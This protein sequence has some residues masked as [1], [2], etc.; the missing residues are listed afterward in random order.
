ML[1]VHFKLM[2]MGI[3][4]GNPVAYEVDTHQSLIV[5]LEYWD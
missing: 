1:R 4:A 2:K 5:H 3:P